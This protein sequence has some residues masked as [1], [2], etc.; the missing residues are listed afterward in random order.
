MLNRLLMAIPMALVWMPLTGHLSIDAFLVG[1]ALGFA[2]LTLLG[3]AGSTAQVTWSQLPGQ[4]AAAV[5]YFLIL[6]RD[7]YLS[8]ID[9]AKRIL[10]PKLP[11]QPGIIAVP[12]Q[13]DLTTDSDSNADILAAVSAHGIT[14]TPGELVVDFDDNRVMYVH[15]LDVDASAQVAESNQAKRL[16]LLRRVFR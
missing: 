16:S 3:E 7:I 11:L 8:S 15:C 13:V 9:V 5:M 14:I 1:L 4:V 10:D 12:T 6:C 2:V